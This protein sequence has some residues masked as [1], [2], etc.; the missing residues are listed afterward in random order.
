MQLRR[1]DGGETCS[2][3]DS[4]VQ[5]A[6]LGGSRGDPA[7]GGAEAVDG[8]DAEDRGDAEDGGDAEDDDVPGTGPAGAG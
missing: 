7:L 5:G 6:V 1:L 3:A 4:A 8:G 2:C